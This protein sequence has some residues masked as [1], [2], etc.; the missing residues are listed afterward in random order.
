MKRL[1][2]ALI[3]VLVVAACA[4]PTPQP[5]PAEPA[6]A[7]TSW[8][9]TTIEATPTLTAKQPTIAFNS[10]RFSGSTGCNS[11][12]GNFTQNGAEMTLSA[13]TVT[14]MACLDTALMTQESRLLTAV[15]QVASV[16]PTSTGADLL[17][18]DRRI[19]LSLTAAPPTPAPKPLL[20]TTW[21]LTG[22][23]SGTT[24]SS[25]VAGSTVTITLAKG[26]YTGKACNTFGGDVTTSGSQ[27]T[28]HAPHSTKMACR[29]AELTAQE[30]T[31]LGMLGE[32]TTWTITGD[33]L[34]LSTPDGAGL[35]FQAS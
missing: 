28:F 22:L 13:A 31:V 16:A 17:D 9:V 32:I 2:W 11:F 21:T 7:D 12:G 15:T 14:Q 23:R 10:T 19:L 5:S 35:D 20:A 6:L 3:G 30:S 29:S 4:T 34:A 8:V 1:P 25:V 33:T 24:A 26:N 27:I 18:Q